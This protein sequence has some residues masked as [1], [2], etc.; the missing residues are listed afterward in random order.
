MAEIVLRKRKGLVR[1]AL[2]TGAPLVPFVCFGNTRVAQPATD[3]LGVMEALSRLLGVSLIWPAGRWGLC[4]PKRV[5]VT[6]V[7]GRPLVPPTEPLVGSTPTTSEALGDLSPP[8]TRRWPTKPAA[9]AA[10]PSG[11]VVSEA[12]VDAMHEQ[13]IQEVS[14]IYYRW[15]A[16]AG[17]REIELEIA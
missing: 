16:S 4:I 2:E 17:Y 13:L 1:I 5:P 7:M 14:A 15:R 6:V 3:G 11:R 9:S 8:L 12:L 10:P